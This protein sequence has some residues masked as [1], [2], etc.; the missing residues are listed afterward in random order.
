MGVVVKATI[1]YSEDVY[2]EDKYFWV[3]LGGNKEAMSIFKRFIEMSDGPDYGYRGQITEGPEVEKEFRRLDAQSKET[4]GHSK[5]IEGVDMEKLM[6]DIRN[7]IDYY[8]KEL[9]ELNEMY[10][11][12]QEIDENDDY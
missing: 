8:I 1:G 4:F 9:A 3:C 10:M 11:K 6:K 2:E 12:L 7:K 5:D